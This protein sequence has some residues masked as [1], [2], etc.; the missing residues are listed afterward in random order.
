MRS[1]EK[2]QAVFCMAIQET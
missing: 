2:P 1:I